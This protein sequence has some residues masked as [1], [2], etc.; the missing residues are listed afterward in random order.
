MNIRKLIL[1]MIVAAMTL[2]ATTCFA[3]GVYEQFEYWRIL[4]WTTVG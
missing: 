3:R 1:P 4:L 2:T